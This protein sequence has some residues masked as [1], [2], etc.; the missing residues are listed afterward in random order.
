MAEEILGGSSMRRLRSLP[1]VGLLLT[2]LVL[3][4]DAYLIKDGINTIREVSQP[5][6]GTVFDL[7][8]AAF[9]AIAVKFGLGVVQFFVLFF[10]WLIWL[11]GRE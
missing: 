5:V 7:H 4:I 1:W 6:T 2:G 11:A 3:A 10:L 8:L 9:A